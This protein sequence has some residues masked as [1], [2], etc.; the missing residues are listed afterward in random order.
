MGSHD[1]RTPSGTAHLMGGQQLSA[2]DAIV[3]L[4]GSWARP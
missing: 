3:E 2:G 4:L 1:E